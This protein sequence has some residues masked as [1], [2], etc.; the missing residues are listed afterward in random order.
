MWQYFVDPQ[1]DHGEAR[2]RAWR[3]PQ[4]EI[5][6]KSLTVTTPTWFILE[7]GVDDNPDIPFDLS[8]EGCAVD[9]QSISLPRVT[10]K[11]TT[12]LHPG[13]IILPY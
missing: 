5:T 3:M 1:G 10:Y 2:Y 11:P 7:Y 12:I 13:L 9:G 4:Y 6:S 8:I